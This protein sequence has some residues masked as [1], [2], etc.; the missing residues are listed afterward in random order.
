MDS[1]NQKLTTFFFQNIYIHKIKINDFGYKI[2]R[3]VGVKY[4]KMTFVLIIW[5]FFAHTHIYLFFGRTIFCQKPRKNKS[6]QINLKLFI[7][8]FL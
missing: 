5:L 3:N 4:K 7:L 1:F 2:L 6:K 8:N